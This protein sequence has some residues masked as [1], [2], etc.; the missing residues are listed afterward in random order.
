MVRVRSKTVEPVIGTL[1]NFTNMKRKHK[2]NTKRQQARTDGIV[3]LQPQEIPALCGE[4]TIVQKL[5]DNQS[6]IPKNRKELRFCK[7]TIL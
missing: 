4:K 3:N 2:R 6:S 5:R 7:K 1:V